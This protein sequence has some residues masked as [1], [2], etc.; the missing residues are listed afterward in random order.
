MSVGPGRIEKRVLKVLE[1]ERQQ[2][3]GEIGRLVG[4]VNHRTE[5]FACDS[6]VKDIT[7]LIVNGCNEE[8]GVYD[9]ESLGKVYR[10]VYQSVCRAIRN[11]ERKGFLKTTIIPGGDVSGYGW[12]KAITLI[13]SGDKH[14]ETTIKNEGVNT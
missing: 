1:W 3:G 9:E 10:S 6:S 12:S 4:T 2:N 14:L 13:K 8:D 7:Y 5:Y 11:L